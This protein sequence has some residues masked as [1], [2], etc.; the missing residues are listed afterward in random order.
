M[1][2]RM[3]SNGSTRIFYA[4]SLVSFEIAPF[5]LSGFA[6]QHRSA[7]KDDFDSVD[8]EVAVKTSA[9]VFKIKYNVFWIL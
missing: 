4:S 2:Y 6:L 3:L 1:F 9:L 8:R 7:F 5:F